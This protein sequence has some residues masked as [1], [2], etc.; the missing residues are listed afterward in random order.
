MLACVVLSS[1]SKQDLITPEN[2]TEATTENAAVSAKTATVLTILPN[3][4][5]QIYITDASYITPGTTILLQGTYKSVYIKNL[6]GTVTSPITIK[7][8]GQVNIGGYGSYT[9]IITG[10]NF[11]ILGNGDATKPYGIKFNSG[12]ISTLYPGSG[13]NV[14]NSYNVEIAYTEYYHVQVGIMQNPSSGL[15]LTN[16]YYHHNYMHDLANPNGKGRSEGFYLGNTGGIIAWNG[17]CR[18]INARIEYNT[19]ENTTGDGI[20]VCNGTF[21][22]KKNV[23]KNYGKA[24]LTDQWYGILMGGYAGGLVTYNTIDGAVTPPIFAIGMGSLEISN[25]II[26]NATLSGSNLD[27]IYINARV[28]SGG[29]KLSLKVLNNTVSGK[30]DRFGI[31]D[32]TPVASSLGGTFTSNTVSGTNKAPYA[33]SSKDVWN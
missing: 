1:C 28:P 18:F 9:C 2:L 11:K 33:I 29:P 13:I 26:K 20:Q 27:L 14:G 5:G 23:I 21:I 3:K 25:N 4:S 19:I 16:I 10:S 8:S 15:A 7:N 6:N 31:A 17:V 32:L 24:K 12:G 30:T 22:I